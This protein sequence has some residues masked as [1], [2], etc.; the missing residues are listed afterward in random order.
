M[1]FT[2]E[3]IASIAAW[4]PIVAGFDRED[5]TIDEFLKPIIDRLTAE[6]RLVVR[7]LQDGGLSNYYSF[8]VSDAALGPVGSD[9]RSAPCVLVQLSL[10]APVGVFGHSTFSSG[11]DFFSWNNLGPEQVCDPAAAED[12]IANAVV[13][14]V[15]EGSPYALLTREVTDRPLPASVEVWEYCLCKQ[16]WD[17]VFHALF[18][19]TD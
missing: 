11:A 3:K 2:D 10:L 4:T 18:A 7:V 12:W 16:P 5:S 9:A 13:A 15:A 1:R 14:A 6:G 19:D 8:Y 17:R